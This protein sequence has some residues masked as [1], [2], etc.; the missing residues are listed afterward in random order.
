MIEQHRTAVGDLQRALDPVAAAPAQRVARL[1]RDDL[2]A[3]WSE[4]VALL[5]DR[6]DGSTISN[7]LDVELLVERAF[8]DA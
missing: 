5:A 1:A 8:V 2:L 7:A 3:A 6:L 4:G